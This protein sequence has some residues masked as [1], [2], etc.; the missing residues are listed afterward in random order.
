M[1]AE[2]YPLA[3]LPRR[4]KAFDYAVPE[5][6]VVS[7][8]SFVMIPLRGKSV[9]GIVKA[10]KQ[11]APSGIK[12]KPIMSVLPASVT[13]RELAVYE[14]LASDLVQSVSSVLDAVIPTPPK[15][16]RELPLTKGEYE[17]VSRSSLTI[18]SDYAQ[19]VT[20]T[21]RFIQARPGCFVRSPDLRHSAAVIATY[22]PWIADY[23]VVFL[24]P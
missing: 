10:V 24:I 13:Q 6:M 22:R 20:E 17:G 3:R 4:F 9:V 2:V 5:G 11:E 23:L 18:P 12:T 7:C 1:F 14:G 19:D 16:L 8:G 15:R 21:V